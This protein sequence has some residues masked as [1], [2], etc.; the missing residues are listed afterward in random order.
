MSGWTPPDT[1]KPLDIPTGAHWKA[2]FDQIASLTGSGWTDY[3]TV[4]PAGG[5]AFTLTAPTTNPTQGNSTYLARFRRPSGSDLVHVEVSITIG[6]T[7]VVGSGVYRFGLPF[8]AAA[9]AVGVGAGYI[10]D[11]GTANR[12]GIVRLGA[13]AYVTFF[14]NAAL[15]AIDH[16]GSGTAWAAGDIIQ[17][18]FSYEPA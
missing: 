1:G 14:L 12:T 6:S 3:T 9:S 15:A 18:S 17:F 11:T 13:A 5:S 16:T 10:L 2:V 7:F 4:A 8:N